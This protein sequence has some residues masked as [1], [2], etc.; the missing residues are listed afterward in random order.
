VPLI[1]DIDFMS[2]KFSVYLTKIK[3]SKRF[4]GYLYHKNLK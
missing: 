1:P 4:E 2:V 3:K